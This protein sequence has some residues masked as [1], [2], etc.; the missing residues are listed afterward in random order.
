[1]ICSS[2]DATSLEKPNVSGRHTTTWRTWTLKQA[3]V[4]FTALRVGLHTRFWLG[5][6]RLAFPRT[7]MCNQHLVN[8]LSVSHQLHCRLVASLK[9]ASFRQVQLHKTVCH[10]YNQPVFFSKGPINSVDA[11][12]SWFGSGNTKGVSSMSLWSCWILVWRFWMHFLWNPGMLAAMR[13]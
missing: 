10:Q 9:V 8:S 12:F 11:L 3:F 4:S 7:F 2:V 1:M 13:D 6:L 5:F